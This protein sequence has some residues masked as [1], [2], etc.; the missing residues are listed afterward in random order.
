M[1]Y[2]VEIEIRNE[3]EE[4][5][6]SYLY[7]PYDEDLF[8]K[9]EEFQKSLD[10]FWYCQSFFESCSLGEHIECMVE[11][12]EES[13]WIYLK[14]HNGVLS[15]C[16]ASFDDFF[17][18][19]ET[20]KYDD[21]C[22]FLRIYE[23]DRAEVLRAEVVEE[24]CVDLD[25]DEPVEVYHY[26]L[27]I[28]FVEDERAEADRNDREEYAKYLYEQE[29]NEES[30]YYALGGSDHDRFKENGGDIDDMLDLAGY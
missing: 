30:A 27:T 2:T 15:L 5:V 22:R 14:N 8:P 13:G 6:P 17:W 24:M 7:D 25:T 9:S 21:V 4:F 12:D 23:V 20:E 28:A 3:N 16:N 18:S 1:K 29:M 19:G 10:F 26:K 11:Y